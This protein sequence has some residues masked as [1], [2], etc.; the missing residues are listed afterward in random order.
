MGTIGLSKANRLFWLGRYLER[1]YTSLKAT[2]Q[3]FD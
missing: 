1:V 3:I 2:R